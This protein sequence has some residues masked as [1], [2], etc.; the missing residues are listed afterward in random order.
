MQV[1][2]TLVDGLK[3]EFKVVVPATELDGR[4]SERLNS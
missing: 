2:E 1:T 4:L 3:R